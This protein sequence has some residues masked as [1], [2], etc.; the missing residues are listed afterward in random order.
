MVERAVFCRNYAEEL[1]MK[2]AE[3]KDLEN[4]HSLVRTADTFDRMAV[5][6]ESWLKPTP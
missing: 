5:I 4:R 1:R 2:A 6:Y 3:K